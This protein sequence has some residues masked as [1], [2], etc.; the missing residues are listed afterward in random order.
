[1]ACQL[2]VLG[3]V[4][5]ARIWVICAGAAGIQLAVLAGVGRLRPEAGWVLSLDQT[6]RGAGPGRRAAHLRQGR[7]PDGLAVP[8]W[9][10]S[11][12]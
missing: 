6:R 7:V 10:G 12:L 2:E 5:P 8:C 1:M 11:A 9:V 4:L 3:L